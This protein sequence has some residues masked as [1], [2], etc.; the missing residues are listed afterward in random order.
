[1]KCKK[2]G[3]KDKKDALHALRIIKSITDGKKKPERAYKCDLCR[4]WH[5]TSKKIEDDTHIGYRLKLD[6]SKL[7][8]N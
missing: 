3:F 2:R 7:Y 1:M 5:L 6:W 4:K 8:N